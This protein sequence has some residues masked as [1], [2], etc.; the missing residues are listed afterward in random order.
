MSPLWPQ[1][2]RGTWSG[3]SGEADLRDRTVRRS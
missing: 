3:I 2:E 1:A